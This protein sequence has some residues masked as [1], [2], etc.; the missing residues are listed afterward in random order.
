[1][2]F[3]LQ[4]FEGSPQIEDGSAHAPF[5][6]LKTGEKTDGAEF[7]DSKI[8]TLQASTLY[9]GLSGGNER[10]RGEEKESESKCLSPIQ[11]RIGPG[12]RRIESV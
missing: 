3:V 10:S 5:V 12:E 1:M 11:I 9:D 6:I 2:I 8:V 4:N 7:A